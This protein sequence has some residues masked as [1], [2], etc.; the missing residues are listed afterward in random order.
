[1]MFD[2]GFYFSFVKMSFDT[3]FSLYHLYNLNL[4]WG[5]PTVDKTLDVPYLYWNTFY[6]LNT[7]I[8]EAMS[9]FVDCWIEANEKAKNMWWPSSPSQYT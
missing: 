3:Y 4:F 1:M 2:T 6:Y 7:H 8:L 9:L 5:V